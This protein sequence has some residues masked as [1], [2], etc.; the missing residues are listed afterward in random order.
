[1]LS[2]MGIRFITVD[3]PG[4]GLSDFQPDR[5]LSDWPGDIGQLADHLGIGEFHVSGHSAGGPH[6]LAC[7]HQLPGR[8]IAG[9][10]ISS[11]APMG[12]PGAYR[13]M[14]LANQL[15]ARCSRHYPWLTKLIRRMMRSMVMGDVEKATRRLM[16]S[17]PDADK[18]LLYAPQHVEI[19]VSA[20]REGFRQGSQAVAQDD[21]LVNREWGFD[22]EHVTP[23]IDIWHGEADV[24]VPVH[25]GWYLRDT[26]PNT[27]A[28]FLPGEGHFFLLGR[29]EEVLSALVSEES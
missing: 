25:A 15:L 22:L 27:R 6:A 18:A 8:V 7:A 24:N 12:R 13:G 14:P 26:L 19:M 28:T 1:M 10:A 2:Q 11:V 3:R 23:R 4:H 29:W 9:A 17:I 5:R 16:S 21:V 20:L